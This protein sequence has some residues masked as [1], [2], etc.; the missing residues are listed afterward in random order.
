M[1]V[2]DEPAL[3]RIVSETLSARGFDV[4]L[5]ITGKQAIGLATSQSFDIC[6]LDIMLPELD[7]YSVAKQLKQISNDLPIIFLSAKSQTKDVIKGFEVGGHDYLRKPFSMEELVVR[8]QNLIDLHK[9]GGQTRR[10][11]QFGIFVFDPDRYELKYE[12]RVIQLSER[13]AS[14]LGILLE[15]KNKTC[16]RKTI[17]IK[18]WG[19]DSYYN[20]RNLDVYV[21]K[22]RKLLSPDHSISIVTLKSVGYLFKVDS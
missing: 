14:I 20:S 8:I 19:D 16:P 4:Q 1:Y 22:L 15:H 2:E 3:A 13:E 18:T 10:I 11:F 5:A 17:L 21:N 6:V 12:D 7:G 9:S